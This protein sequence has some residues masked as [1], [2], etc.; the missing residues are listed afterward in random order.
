VIAKCHGCGVEKDLDVPEVYPYP[1]DD[2]RDDLPPL[3]TMDCQSEDVNG[4]WRNVLLCYECYHKFDPDMW[5][6]QR[7]WESWKT[8]TPFD[9]LPYVDG[10]P[11]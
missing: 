5:I 3:L 6:L 1:E 7:Q 10:E 4:R 8:A 9:E 2:I 11:K